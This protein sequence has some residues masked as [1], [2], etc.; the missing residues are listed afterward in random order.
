[1]KQ[2]IIDIYKRYGF[3]LASD[4]SKD[5]ILVFTLKNGYFH[6]AEIVKLDSDAKTEK[7]FES[8]SKS[9]YACTTRL[10]VSPE[11]AESELFK[12]FF[13]VESTRHRLLEDYRRFSTNIVSVYGKDAKYDYIK[14]PYQINGKDGD[15]SPAEEVLSLINTDEPILFLIEAAAGFGKTCTAFE[16]LKLLAEDESHLPLYAELS[17]NRQARIFRYILLDEIDRSFPLLS[18]RL[19]QSEIRNGRIIT[20]LDGFDELLRKDDDTGSFENQEPM[21]ETV[22]ELLT[23]HAKIIITTRRTVLFDGDEFHQWLDRHATNFRLIRIR[24][25]EPRVTDWLSESRLCQ[26]EQADLR[27]E[28]MANPVLL[29]YLRCINEKSFLEAVSNPESIVES[30]FTYM[31]DRERERQDLRMDIEVQH[32][33][34]RSIAHDMMQCGYTAE[35]RDYIIS[36]I[37][38]SQ[39]KALDDTRTRY[40]VTDKPNREEIANKLA[41]HALLDRSANDPNKISFVNE[42]AFGNY[43]AENIFLM[44]DWMSDDL[45]FI[46]PAVGSYKPRNPDS[47]SRLYEQL[48][49]SLPFLDIGS[50]IEISIDLMYKILFPLSEGEAEGI[51]FTDIEIGEFLISNFQFNECQFSKCRFNLQNMDNVTFL[52]CR[53]YNCV[54]PIS[55]S[56]APIFVLGG[57]GDPEFIKAISHRPTDPSDSPNNDCSLNIEAFILKKLWPIGESYEHMPSRPI[58]KPLKVLCYPT[59]IY[60]SERLYDSVWRMKKKGLIVETTRNSLITINQ[61]N[62]SDIQKILLESQHAH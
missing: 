21:L 1:M 62:I 7:A 54:L 6:N 30:Y 49:E 32:S 28:A 39:Q 20:I 50:R 11:Q 31:L 40:P 10:V 22:S 53:F 9:G 41:S 15:L 60:N 19:V 55:E 34:L 58:F 26:L 51:T 36:Y 14:S 2:R 33:I 17:R 37:L 44:P 18:S 42:F 5:G 8:F 16:I 29:S 25:Q 12:G 46:E 13:S 45:R 35:E 61:E 4:Q 3:Q 48:N 23:G 52:N 38:S 24:I 47:R 27:I 56:R 59:R 43:V 57:S